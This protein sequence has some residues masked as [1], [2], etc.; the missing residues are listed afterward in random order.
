[1]FLRLVDPPTFWGR[2]DF[3]QRE[4]PAFLLRCRGRPTRIWIRCSPSEVR[5]PWITA[6]L[7]GWLTY[8][9]SIGRIVE[10]VQVLRRQKRFRQVPA[11]LCQSTPTA[12]RPDRSI[13]KNAVQLRSR[14]LQNLAIPG[15]ILRLIA[16][17]QVI[18]PWETCFT[19]HIVN[20]QP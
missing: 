9:L 6:T 11:D 15:S 5:N 3:N 8:P 14:T 4:C 20:V 19:S 16:S 7:Q 17:K 13:Q 18:I 10:R 12:Q 1:M 2:V